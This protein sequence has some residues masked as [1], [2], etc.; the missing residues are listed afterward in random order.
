MQ[1][2][3]NIFIKFKIQKTRKHFNNLNEM[4]VICG[5]KSNFSPILPIFPISLCNAIRIQLSRL[6]PARLSGNIVI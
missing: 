4:E 1:I 3:T 5:R 6:T 2:Q